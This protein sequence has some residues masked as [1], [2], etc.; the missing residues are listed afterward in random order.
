MMP[1]AR[2]GMKAMLGSARGR[3]LRVVVEVVERGSVAQEWGSE[4]EED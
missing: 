3:G 2:A 1:T 4:H